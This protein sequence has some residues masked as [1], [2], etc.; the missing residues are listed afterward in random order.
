MVPTAKGTVPFPFVSFQVYSLLLPSISYCINLSW[1]R[2]IRAT[3]YI[4][5]IGCSQ[6]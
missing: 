1:F 2:N 6:I 4:F 5:S 3:F